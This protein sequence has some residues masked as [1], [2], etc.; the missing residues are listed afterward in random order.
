[1]LHQASVRR[2][3]LP[4]TR[5]RLHADRASYCQGRSEVGKSEEGVRERKGCASTVLLCVSEAK[6]IVDERAEGG[7]QIDLEQRTARASKR[8]TFGLAVPKTDCSRLYEDEGRFEGSLH[9]VGV[10]AAIR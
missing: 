1:M 9:P 3:P 5:D 8:T 6:G 10:V 2:Q 7:Q 4:K